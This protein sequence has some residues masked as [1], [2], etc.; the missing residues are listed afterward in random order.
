MLVKELS[1]DKIK[2]VVFPNHLGE[3]NTYEVSEKFNLNKK[4]ARKYPNIKSYRGFNVNNK[5]DRIAF[6]IS[7]KG[8][9][10]LILNGN[11]NIVID[12]IKSQKY[13]VYKDAS[14]A[15][16]RDSEEFVSKHALLDSKKKTL[17]S[18]S[19]GSSGLIKLRLAILIPYAYTEI[20]G[21]TTESVLENLNG[22][23]NNINAV[24][25]L[26]LNIVYEIV[27]NNDELIF[28]NS[29]SDPF[30]G[31]QIHNNSSDWAEKTQETIDSFIGPENYDIG[32]L[33]V[34]KDETENTE[35]GIGNAGSIGG[36]PDQSLYGSGWSK[37]SR[38]T[39]NKIGF[40]W[41]LLHEFAP[42]YI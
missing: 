36:V 37:Y 13:I 23:I 9:N 12:K 3:F 31:E 6:S 30:K 33:F 10:T 27:E 18:K 5:K 35:Y 1:D 25:E 32:H 14:K 7:N 16:V 2:K 34:T 11:E 15:K 39:T 28:L 41:L 40:V 20:H 4:L 24:S 17:A 38:N 8:M 19:N 22:I 42:N 29:T 26:D 21:G